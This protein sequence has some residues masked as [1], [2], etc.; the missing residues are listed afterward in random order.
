MSKDLRK[1]QVCSGSLNFIHCFLL[2]S[3][4]FDGNMGFERVE[5]RIYFTCE[6]TKFCSYEPA[7]V[8]SCGVKY[9]ENDTHENL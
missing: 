5:Q 1:F 7:T 4:R 9:N 3:F 2:P 6:E 8:R